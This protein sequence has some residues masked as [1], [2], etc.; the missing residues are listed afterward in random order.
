MLFFAGPTGVGKTEMAKTLSEF[1]FGDE[2]RIIRFDMSEYNHEESDQKLIG[3]APGYVGYEN[4]GQLTNSV[5]ENPFSILLFDEIEKGN[6]KIFDIFLQILE[7]GRLTSSKGE[8]VDFSET[9]IIFTSNIGSSTFSNDMSELEAKKH[10]K[11]AV[12]DYFYKTLNRPEILNRIGL[13]NII[14]F[15]P[16]NTESAYKI[17]ELKF[18]KICKHLEDYKNIK[19]LC[20]SK[21][22]LNIKKNI[23]YKLDR[24]LGG[25]GIVTKLENI[26]VDQF[27]EYLFENYE[28]FINNKERKTI[29]LETE[30][31]DNDSKIK[32]NFNIIE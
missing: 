18:K 32:F 14:P 7:D 3:S 13:K 23:C 8:L 20:N 5:L 2:K 29:N 28:I 21:N 24:T 26:F 1:V 10:F 11:N 27:A 22:L 9:F 12:I 25:R 16:L 6:Q 4:G 15:L 17:I 30:L 19:L 31:S